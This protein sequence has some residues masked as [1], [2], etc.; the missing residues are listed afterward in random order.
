MLNEQMRGDAVLAEDMEEAVG[1][2][3]D[4]ARAKILALP[5]TAAPQ[6]VGMTDPAV[7]RDLLTELVHDICRDLAKGP[8]AG[9][10][11]HR[12]QQRAGGAASDSEDQPKVGSPAAPDGQRMG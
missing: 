4:G 6:L 3:V 5:T 1:A 2:L 9:A 11:R 7:V 10:V 12:A 8:A